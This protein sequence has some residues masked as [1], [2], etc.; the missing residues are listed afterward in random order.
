[1]V[2][3]ERFELSRYCY[4][5]PLNSATQVIARDLCLSLLT[6]S[7]RI[8]SHVIGPARKVNAD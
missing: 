5:Q 1:M 6:R 7:G 4:R 2:R 3:K 8:R